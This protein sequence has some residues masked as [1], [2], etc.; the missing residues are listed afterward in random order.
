MVALP[1]AGVL[2]ALYITKSGGDYLHGRLLLPSLVAIVAPFAAVPW[3]PKLRV[4]IAV[5]GV[6]A[7]LA[8]TLL[9][10]GEHRALVPVTDHGVVLG[11]VLM[12]D[13]TRPGRDPILATDFRFDDGP[14]AARLQR[15]GS[16]RSWRGPSPCWT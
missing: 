11:R 4:P 15:R 3:R 12:S 13:L 8:L 1:V 14:V 16:A 6:W 10:P 2:H 9:R 5:V 7:L